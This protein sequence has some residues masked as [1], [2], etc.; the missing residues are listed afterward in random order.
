MPITLKT[1]DLGNYKLVFFIYVPHDNN[2]VHI[3]ITEM[4]AEQEPQRYL[5]Y[6]VYFAKLS[7]LDSSK[8]CIVGSDKKEM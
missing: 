6:P 2:K 1:K 4:M 5:F 8:A 3:K 7:L